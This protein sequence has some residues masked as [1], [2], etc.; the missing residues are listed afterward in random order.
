MNVINHE[1]LEKLKLVQVPGRPDV[2][3]RVIELFFSTMPE[4]VQ[5]IEKYYACT[6]LNS[7]AREAHSLKSSARTVGAES[8][9]NLC[10]KIESQDFSALDKGEILNQLKNEVV[11]V[12]TELKSVL[13]SRST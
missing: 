1:T 8:M 9:A 11:S 13:K 6:D 7:M 3:S 5:N 12:T 10:Q 2:I 4:R